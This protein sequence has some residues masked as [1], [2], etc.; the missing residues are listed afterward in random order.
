MSIINGITPNYC[1]IFNYILTPIFLM[2]SIY[3]FFGEEYGWRFFLQ[4][5]FFDKFGKKLG[6][7]VL[8][9][10]WSLWHLPL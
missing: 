10:C 4:N 1:R 7:L 6:V 9:V 3:M 2:M 5:I 8:D